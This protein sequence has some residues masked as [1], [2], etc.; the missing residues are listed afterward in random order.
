IVAQTVCKAAEQDDVV[1]DPD[2]G[3][4]PAAAARRDVGSTTAPTRLRKRVS[5]T[6][7][8][9]EAGKAAHRLRVHTSPRLDVGEAGVATRTVRPHVAIAYAAIGEVRPV[10]RS[11]AV[12]DVRP[13]L[14]R[15]QD[16][17]PVTAAEVEAALR[18][19][20]D[21]GEFLPHRVIVV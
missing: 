19:G 18:A 2:I 20:I 5:A 14:I 6:G 16:L 10:S 11:P 7:M 8:I 15:P 21:V 9:G 13:I 3:P 12:A 17:L 1:L 4:P